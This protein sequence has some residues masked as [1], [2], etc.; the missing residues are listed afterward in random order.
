MNDKERAASE[1]RPVKS[2]DDLPPMDEDV[3]VTCADGHVA[4]A[5]VMDYMRTPSRL[6]WDFGEGW[7]ENWDYVLAWM[8]LPEAYKGVTRWQ[9]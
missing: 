8:P 5:S 2:I 7:Y 6:G 3:L 1:W 4:I 9:F